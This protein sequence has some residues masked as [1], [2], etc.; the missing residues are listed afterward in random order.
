MSQMPD[1]IRKLRDELAEQWFHLM[2]EYTGSK[3]HCVISH[4][5]GF[6][7]CY[8]HM[9]MREAALL[10]N[11]GHPVPHGVSLP[12]VETNVLAEFIAKGRDQLR[13]DLDLAIEALDKT[14]AK[15]D[16]VKSEL[17]GHGLEVANWHKN[18]ALEPMESWFDDNDWESSEATETLAK[19]RARKDEK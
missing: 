18:G 16:A 3:R 14:K 12:D 7:A 1:D 6:D 10:G 13:A 19:L 17:Y 4:N 9:A 2:D 15:L 11:L 8:E 5:A